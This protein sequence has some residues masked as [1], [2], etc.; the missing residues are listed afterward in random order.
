MEYLIFSIYFIVF[1]AIIVN[2]KFFQSTQMSKKILIGLFVIKILFSGFYFAYY[3]NADRPSDTQRFF[4]QAKTLYQKS[5]DNPRQFFNIISNVSFGRQTQSSGIFGII[6]EDEIPYGTDYTHESRFVVHLTAL[7]MFFSGPY[8]LVLLL[9]YAFFAF[10]GSV[11]LYKY[12]APQDKKNQVIS[13]I[14][15]FMIPST[16][17][18]A[19]GIS[20]E[21]LFFFFISLTL[22]V[23]HQCIYQKWGIKYIVILCLS[24]AGMMYS[25]LHLAIIFIPLMFI[26]IFCYYNNNKWLIKYGCGLFILFIISVVV[27]FFA[28]DSYFDIWYA[29]QY[30]N[31]C[32]IGLEQHLHPDG[33][34]DIYLPFLEDSFLSIFNAIPIALFN[35]IY[36]PAIQTTDIYHFFAGM[37]TLL[38]IGLSIN[39]CIR[40]FK[41]KIDNDSLFL[42]L[43]CLLSFILIGLCTPNVG[44][45]CRYKSVCLPFLFYLSLN[46]QNSFRPI[47]SHTQNNKQ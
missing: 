40:L 6:P 39:L 36:Y 45:L 31:N 15:C 17:F 11:F 43:F 33:Q 27:R 4:T 7:L 22:F 21:V 8:Y 13:I 26:Y 10:C 38:F 35:V 12:F 5:F 32:F 46:T 24:L 2:G 9:I 42:L 1:I 18:W 20:K 14:A 30:Q 34:T 29:I 47:L 44:A 28:Y 41:R 19:S 37:E 16:I 3:K 25:K 23:L